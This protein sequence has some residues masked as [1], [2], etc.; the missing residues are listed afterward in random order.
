MR[1][2]SLKTLIFLGRNSCD[3]G[4]H[5]VLGIP[6][7]TMWAHVNELEK[8]L[9]VKLVNRKKQSTSL[10]EEAKSF[11]PYAVKLLDIYQEGIHSAHGENSQEV[12]S[13]LVIS[14]TSAVSGSWLMP[15]LKD[16]YEKHQNLRLNIIANDIVPKQIERTSDILLR[17]VSDD[18]EGFQK[19]WYIP[20]HH[21]LFAS[22]EYVK[23]HG[24]PKTP[25]DLLKHKVLAYGEHEF[26][27]FDDVNW[28]TKGKYGIPKL[29][30][31]ITVNS[32]VSL[33]NAAKEGLGI[34]SAPQESNEIYG[35]ELINVLPKIK[36]PTIKTYFCMKETNNISAQKHMDLFQKFMEEYFKEISVKVCYDKNEK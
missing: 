24:S 1:I 11:I 28:H 8:E 6:R 18:L 27:Y 21:L 35:G 12:R 17:P 9:G 2:I 34:I 5:K 20:Y 4:G 10:T 32:T 22:K 33:F 25:N 15:S 23:K 36:G 13:E 31:S 16:F 3:F 7:S 26:S 29:T 19:F 14:T 30:P